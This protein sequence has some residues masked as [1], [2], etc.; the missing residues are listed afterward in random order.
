[1]NT[2]V[3]I[4]LIFW[5]LALWMIAGPRYWLGPFHNDS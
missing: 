1:M 2:L 5:G 4:T 3:A